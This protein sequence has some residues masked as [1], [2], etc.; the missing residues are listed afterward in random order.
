[1]S[2]SMVAFKEHL[3]KTGSGDLA[4]ALLSLNSVCD[5]IGI[6]EVSA[7]LDVIARFKFNDKRVILVEADGTIVIPKRE[8]GKDECKDNSNSV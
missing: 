1:M 4:D 7:L 6:A 5:D 8:E 2:F 3:E